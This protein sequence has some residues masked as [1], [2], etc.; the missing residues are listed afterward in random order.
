[1]STTEFSNKVQFSNDVAVTGDLDIVG[2]LQPYSKYIIAGAHVMNLNL[3]L[4]DI[5]RNVITGSV[6]GV[7]DW[8]NESLN[9]QIRL[10]LGRY[11]INFTFRYKVTTVSNTG[12]NAI[13]LKNISTNT[14]AYQTYRQIRNATINDIGSFNGSTVINQTNASHLWGLYSDQGSTTSLTLEANSSYGQVFV[15]KM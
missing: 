13:I 6:G 5:A 14:T 15:K 12:N 2:F 1:M 4:I 3:Q 7:T 8:S 11:E 9:G 10:P